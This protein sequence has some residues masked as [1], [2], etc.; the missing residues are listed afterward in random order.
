[1]K[2]NVDYESTTFGEDT[3]PGTTVTANPEHVILSRVQFQF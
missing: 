3:H 2:L 1:V